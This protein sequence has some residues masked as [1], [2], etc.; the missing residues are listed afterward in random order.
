M[1]DFRKFL[2]KELAIQLRNRGFVFAEPDL[3]GIS[4]FDIAARREEDKFLIKI[5]Y[6]IETMRDEGARDL[7]NVSKILGCV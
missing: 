7:M 6:N 2:L 3:D 1:E 4:A 5:L